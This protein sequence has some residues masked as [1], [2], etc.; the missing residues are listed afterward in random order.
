MCYEITTSH[1]DHLL[2]RSYRATLIMA[3]TV[4]YFIRSYN[5][6]EFLVLLSSLDA[7]CD[8]VVSCIFKQLH[9]VTRHFALAFNS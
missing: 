9:R 6:E 5:E 8:G 3:F 2:L 4:N 1:R 7:S